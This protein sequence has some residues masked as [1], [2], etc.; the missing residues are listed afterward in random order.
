MKSRG[1]KGEEVRSDHDAA[2]S[3]ERLADL[4]R[5]VVA[6]PKAEVPEHKPKHRR[7]KRRR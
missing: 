4:T 6:V 2:A 3:L 1:H 5:R 7:K